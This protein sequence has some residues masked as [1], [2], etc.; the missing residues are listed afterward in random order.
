[1][2]VS[3]DDVR[4]GFRFLYE[5][6]KL[7]AEPGAAVGVGAALA[8]KIDGLEGKT[9]CFVISGGNVSPKTASGILDGGEG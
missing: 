8:G 7:A 4:V 2:L 1:M 3:E 9:A 5:R 6:A